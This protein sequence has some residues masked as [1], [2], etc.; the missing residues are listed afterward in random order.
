MLEED[1]DRDLERAKKR[2]TS[3]KQNKQ[4]RDPE[5]KEVRHNEEMFARSLS[6]NVQQT[7]GN[8]ICCVVF[9]SRIQYIYCYNTNLL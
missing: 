5:M 9:V 2:R 8:I 4:S 1:F 3:Q 6:Y 7:S